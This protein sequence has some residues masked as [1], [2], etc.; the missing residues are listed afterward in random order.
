MICGTHGNR[1]TDNWFTSVA[2]SSS[3]LSGHKVTVVGTLRRNKQKIPIEIMDIGP[4]AP[5]GLFL[6]RM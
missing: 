6:T 1:A 2:L 4:W 3:V 5:L